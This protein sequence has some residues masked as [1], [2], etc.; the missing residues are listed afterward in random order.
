MGNY[1]Y[2]AAGSNFGSGVKNE[3]FYF[4]FFLLDHFKEIIGI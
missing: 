2:L 3:Y 1:G 4:I